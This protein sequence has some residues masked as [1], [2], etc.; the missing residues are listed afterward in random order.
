LGLG[1]K[2]L[3]AVQLAT[4]EACSNVLVHA[5]AGKPGRL[6]VEVVEEPEGIQVVVRDWGTAFDPESVP[7]PDLTLPLEERK[8]GGLGVYMMRKLMDEITYHFDAEQGNRLVMRRTISL[9]DS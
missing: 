5:Y 1:S 7:E 2:D 6:E 8:V 9:A 3:W 4:E